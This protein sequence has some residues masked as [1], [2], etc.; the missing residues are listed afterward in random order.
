[1]SSGRTL[2]CANCGEPVQLRRGPFLAMRRSDRLPLC[3]ECGRFLSRERPG[4][5]ET[6]GAA[7]VAQVS[8]GEQ[9]AVS[10]LAGK[11]RV[12]GKRGKA[13]ASLRLKRV[14]GVSYDDGVAE[15]E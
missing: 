12:S 11:R 3:R 13:L 9:I 6:P 1:M 10:R 8:D 14:L 7:R 15:D 5:G 4:E 2:P